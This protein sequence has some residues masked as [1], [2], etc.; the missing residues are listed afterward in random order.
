[1]EHWRQELTFTPIQLRPSQA[2]VDHRFAACLLLLLAQCTEYT[3]DDKSEWEWLTRIRPAQSHEGVDS[4]LIKQQQLL[5]NGFL[6]EWPTIWKILAGSL[7]EHSHQTPQLPINAI[8]FNAPL[9]FKPARDREVGDVAGTTIS[10][11]EFRGSRFD[12]CYDDHDGDHEQ[13][14]RPRPFDDRRGF[15]V[16][17][18]NRESGIPSPFPGKKTGIGGIRFPI[19]E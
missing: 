6:P 16:S 4:E 15:P 5:Q 14:G 2:E 17:R 1:M 18:P 12:R 3:K 19:P 9:H 11:W 8:R 13:R 10:Q 7:S